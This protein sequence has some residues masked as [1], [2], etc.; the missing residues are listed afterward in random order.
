MRPF[1]LALLL[2]M[3]TAFAHNVAVDIN[4]A[5]RGDTLEARLR[6]PALEAITRAR[7]AYALTSRETDAVFSAPL[8][9]VAEA[10]V[11]RVTLPDLPPGSYTLRLTDTTF[12]G[13]TLQALTVVTLPLE[14]PARLRFP[15]S[16]A[17]P[18]ATLVIVLA[19]TPIAL[20]LIAVV[21]VLLVH[22]NAKRLRANHRDPSNT[23]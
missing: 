2:L 16:N 12:P 11:Y 5:Q 19:L 22:P 7:I 13:E 18:D 15:A 1:I 20:S 21:V 8:E 6:G 4:V 14:T 17:A 10:G 23:A 3:P 9:E